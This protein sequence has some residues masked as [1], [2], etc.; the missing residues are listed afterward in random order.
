MKANRK[1]TTDYLID[2]MQ[3]SLI[4]YLISGLVFTVRLYFHRLIMMMDPLNIFKITKVIEYIDKYIGLRF[5]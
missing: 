2:R 1:V 5:L 3:I 4:P